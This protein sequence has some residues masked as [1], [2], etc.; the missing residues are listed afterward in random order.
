ML[1]GIDSPDLRRLAKELR[2]VDRDFSVAVNRELR[3]ATK[4]MV[5]ALKQ[6]AKVN[7]PDFLDG[8]ALASTVTSSASL[9]RTAVS[10]RRKRGKPGAGQPGAVDAGYVRHPLF[11]DKSQ[12][13]DTQTPESAGWFSKVAE[14]LEPEVMDRV[15]EAVLLIISRLRSG[16]L[17][18]SRLGRTRTL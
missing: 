13:F 6:S 18:T 16:N 5:D 3:E 8:A 14:D 10:R 1:V 12:W 4:P 17:V 11:G 15:T 7:A 9:G 2:A